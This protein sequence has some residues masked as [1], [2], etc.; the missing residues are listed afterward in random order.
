LHDALAEVFKTRT[1]LEW[2]TEMSSD[3]I[4]CGMVRD[5]SE[6]AQ[7]SHLPG[8]KMKL[9]ISVEGLPTSETVDIVN[10]GFLMS[11]DGPMIDEPPPRLDQHRDEIL[12]WLNGSR[13]QRL[14]N[15][16]TGI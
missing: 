12:E 3:G 7:F 11:E 2:E 6:A 14:G 16:R 5:V 10:A 1:A 15:S 9:P 4:P 13:E 8:R